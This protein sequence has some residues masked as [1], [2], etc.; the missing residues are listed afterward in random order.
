MDGDGW[1]QAYLLD[2]LG[3]LLEFEPPAEPL[4]AG[5][6]ER[7]GLELTA[8]EAG[9]ALKAEIAWYRRNHDDAS[10]RA[11][12]A[13]LRRGAALALRAALPPAGRAL[14]VEPL[15]G[16][17]LD[18]IRFRP[19]PEVDGA[20]R[21]ARERGIRLVVVSN[22]DVSLHDAL[23]A[24]GLAPLL[25]GVV[26]SAETGSA[27]PGGAIFARGLELAG[28][29]AAGALHVGDDVAADVEGARAAGIAVRLV[30]RDGTAAP[31]GVATVGS[32]AELPGIGAA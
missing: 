13:E 32:L 30:V 29:P 23:E 14:P 1:P 24:T 16:V 10:D 31:P 6:R 17:L 3:T 21:R 22:W 8:A 11:R 2:A 4:R 27:K 28:V 18:A 19:F 20:L 12:L 25:D 9:A 15:T 7:F 26:T 5:V